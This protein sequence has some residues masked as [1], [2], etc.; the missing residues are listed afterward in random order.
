VLYTDACH[1]QAGGKFQHLG[2]SKTSI[3]VT[4]LGSDFLFQQREQ[5]NKHEVQLMNALFTIWLF[6]GAV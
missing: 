6:P 2:F 3:Q 1:G 5:T 4:F